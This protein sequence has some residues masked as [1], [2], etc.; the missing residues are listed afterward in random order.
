M[1]KYTKKDILEKRIS[2]KPMTEEQYKK[3]CEH[4]G[5]EPE[6]YGVNCYFRFYPQRGFEERNPHYGVTNSYLF[7]GQVIRSTHE[8]SFE[9]FDFEELKQLP[10]SFC[11]KRD[12]DNPLWRK[13]VDS[14]NPSFKGNNNYYGVRRGSKSAWT[15]A[16]ADATELTLEEWDAIVNPKFKVDDWV[17]IISTVYG[18]RAAMNK[19]G[20]IVPKPKSTGTSIHGLCYSDHPDYY[21]QI[22]DEVWAVS[23]EFRYAA[24]E[25]IDA[26]FVL[27]KK[28]H[29]KVTEVNQKILSQWS[30]IEQSFLEV[31]YICG[32]VE[33]SGSYLTQKRYRPGYNP[34]HII[35]GEGIGHAYDFG[36]EITF[37]Q[38]KKYVLKENTMEKKILGYKWK[39]GFKEQYD[40]AAA[41]IC[42]YTAYNPGLGS[43]GPKYQFEEGSSNSRALYKAGVLD[44]WFEPV[45]EEDKKV[46]TLKCSS[47]TFELQVSKEGIYYAPDDKWLSPSDLS[48]AIAPE[49][50]QLSR[51]CTPELNGNY[52]WMKQYV[53]HVDLGC[54]TKTSAEDI[55]AVVDYF[56]SLQ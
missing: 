33:E 38:F 13:F 27:P 26:A 31:G 42:G 5:F 39:E 21:I 24:S 54:K 34:G 18:C 55:K 44:L 14:L 37:N 20:R 6:Y 15:H 50:I 1:T 29:V 25:E 40:K 16:P 48:R 53:S 22:N 51:G 49:D 30:G 3:L 8:I 11:I 45:Y 4:F 36:S 23:G 52:Y 56:Y 17:Y 7:A 41:S 47:G 35:S 10:E 12:A 9:E 19:V 2:F 32:M 28:W 43:G 46:F